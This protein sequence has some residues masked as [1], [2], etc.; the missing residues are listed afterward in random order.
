M[1]FVIHFFYLSRKQNGIFNVQSLFPKNDN[2]IN[3]QDSFEEEGNLN[4][5]VL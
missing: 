5:M 1:F 2:Y 4:Y 3:G